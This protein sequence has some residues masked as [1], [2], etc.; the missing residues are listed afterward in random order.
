MI[1]TAW[2][3]LYGDHVRGFKTLFVINSF[4]GSKDYL[5]SDRLFKLIGDSMVSFRKKTDW[6]RNSC[7]LSGCDKELIPHKG[8]KRKIQEGYDFLDF[9][10]PD[11]AQE[12]DYQN[13]FDN[14]FKS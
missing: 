7:L 9:V 3:K 1:A 11:D 12:D 14:L 4:D 5:L 13:L 2:N 6:I 10:S 8:I